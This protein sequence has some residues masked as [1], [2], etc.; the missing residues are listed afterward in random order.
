MVMKKR[1]D[2]QWIK[3]FWSKAEAWIDANFTALFDN[4]EELETE[5]TKV[6]EDVEALKSGGGAETPDYPD[7]EYVEDEYTEEEMDAVILR[8]ETSEQS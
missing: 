4:D 6:K 2:L 8:G 5:L 3:K 7:L 1:I